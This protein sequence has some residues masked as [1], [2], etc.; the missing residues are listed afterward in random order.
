MTV[1]SQI[2]FVRLLGSGSLTTFAYV[3]TAIEEEDVFVFLD[4]LGDGTFVLQIEFTHYT[5]ENTTDN[6]GDIE[7]VEAPPSGSEVII[8]RS[9]PITQQVDYL[10]NT[11]FP[12][13][14]HEGGA[15]KLILILQELVD[16]ISDPSD[17]GD[18]DYDLS[19]SQQ[20]ATVTIVNE[21]GTDAQIPPWDSALFAGVF[22]GE[23]TVSAPA[24]KSV[25]TKAD[26]FI[27]IEVAP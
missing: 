5:Y 4:A 20:A 14:T 15:D 2:P 21:A 18:V 9:T 12:A 16:G 19:V 3:W 17:L 25:T 27:F 10:D 6:G 8:L 13:E 22:H 7:F 1:N 24:D 26:G 11:P 23:I